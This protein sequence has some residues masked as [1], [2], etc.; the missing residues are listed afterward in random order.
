MKKL[1]I[2]MFVLVA[3]VGLFAQSSGTGF[4]IPELVSLWT[5]PGFT[6]AGTWSQSADATIW[7]NTTAQSTIRYS[8]S[9]KIGQTGAKI[10]V[11]CAQIADGLDIKV[12]RSDEFL[13]NVNG[14]HGVVHYEGDAFEPNNL[15]TLTTNNQDYITDIFA[16]TVDAINNY[17]ITFD[18]R[19]SFQDAIEIEYTIMLQND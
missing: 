1:F 4:Q 14:D 13:S 3:C 19:F 8:T 16:C 15:L 11:R 18:S 5:S 2:M 6:E 12:G 10:Q 9:S 7:T 17:E